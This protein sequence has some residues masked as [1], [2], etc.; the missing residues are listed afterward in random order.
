MNLP[1]IPFVMTVFLSALTGC[2]SG[3]LGSK[4]LRDVSQLS[5]LRKGHSTKSDVFELLGQPTDVIWY[6][7]ESPIYPT[8]KALWRYCRLAEKGRCVP[9]P[10]LHLL[11]SV[12]SY[13]GAAAFIYFDERGKFDHYQFETNSGSVHGVQHALMCT[14]ALNAMDSVPWTDII[15]TEM[16][17][18]G[19]PFNP[20]QIDK[21]G[22]TPFDAV[23][24]WK[25]LYLKDGPKT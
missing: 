16:E 10:F 11:T 13:S 17:R 5:V 18:V 12:C 20:A 1:A 21:S 7:P 24:L 14:R 15:K 25:A 4:N 6:S 22:R 19:K 8:E 23:E 2:S 3:V 9:L